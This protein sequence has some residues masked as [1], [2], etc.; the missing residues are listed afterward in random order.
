MEITLLYTYIYYIYYIYLLYTTEYY[1]LNCIILFEI[2]N[3]YELFL[4]RIIIIIAVVILFLWFNNY[5]TNSLDPMH[6]DFIGYPF[7]LIVNIISFEFLFSLLCLISFCFNIHIRFLQSVLWWLWKMRLIIFTII[8]IS[9]T[10][11]L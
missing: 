2:H 6:R 1:I 7:T 4:Y 5:A 11:L 9:L 3:L 10:F 8:I